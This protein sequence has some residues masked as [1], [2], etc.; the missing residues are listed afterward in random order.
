MP[1]TRS[2]YAAR[3]DDAL[4]TF[5]R[6]LSPSAAS[7]FTSTGAVGDTL[8]EHHTLARTAWPAIDVPL[9]EFAG[10][11][12]RRMGDGATFASLATCR[13]TDVYL[14]IASDRGDEAATKTLMDI[15]HRE[16][17]FAARKTSA[18]ADQAADVEAEL[19]RLL[20]TAE[21]SRRAAVRDFSGRGDFRGYVRVIATRELVRRVKRDRREA[22]VAEDALFALLTP[23][24][25]AELAVLRAKYH[26]DVDVAVRAAL[27][28][29]DDRSRAL[30]RYAVVDGWTVDRI[31]LLY[32][33]H[34]ATAARWVAGVRE[35]LGAAIR[36][37]VAAR[38]AISIDEVDSIVR[39]VQSQ[40]DVSFVRLMGDQA[41]PT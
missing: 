21:P 23:E 14:T 8:R 37:E 40:L 34:R 10:E 4:D 6:H 15:V 2:R 19:N 17:A 29:L 27:A 41:N 5:L 36:E 13:A 39:L 11:L 16:V 38:L 24:Q 20:W 33:V 3:V 30:L 25:D 9:D 26:G 28:K 35:T 22:P 7:A 31:G 18:T 12:A 32:G 1:L